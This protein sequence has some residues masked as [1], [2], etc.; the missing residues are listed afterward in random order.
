MT[1]GSDAT[2]STQDTPVVFVGEG[3]ARTPCSPAATCPSAGSWRRHTSKASAVPRTGCRG[4]TVRPR[5]GAHLLRRAA[6]QGGRRHLSRLPA[7]H[8]EAG[9]PDLRRLRRPPRRDH[10]RGLRPAPARPGH[11]Q[12]ARRRAWSTS[13]RPGPARSTGSGRAACCASCATASA[14]P[15]RAAAPP[16]QRRYAGRSSWCARSSPTTSAWWRAP[17]PTSG[18]STC[19]SSPRATAGPTRRR[20]SPPPAPTSSSTAPRPSPPSRRRFAGLNWVCATTARQRDLAKPVLTP[21]QAVAE[22][23]RRLARGPAL[24]HRVRAR[25]QRPGDGGGGQRRRRGHGAGQPSFASLNLAQAVLLVEL[26]VDEAVGRRN[27]RAGDHLR[28]AA[29]SPVCRPA[30]RRRRAGTSSSAF[31]EHIERELDA[32]GFFTAP[33]KRPSVVQNLRSMFVRMGATEQ[34]IRTL[35]GIVKALVHPKRGRRAARLSY[36]AFSPSDAALEERQ[37][38]P[39]RTRSGTT[40]REGWMR[41]GA[42]RCS[43]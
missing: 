27:A 5:A 39:T 41:Q 23:R 30:A 32:S 40:A 36:A 20:A 11:R 13:P 35:R 4:S 28:G 7:A 2:L 17:W 19:A 24:R 10:L 22:M 14:A 43:T 15:R 42:R 9:A 25:A 29:S 26:R 31:F 16:A 3:D 12:A 8:P 21:E 6:L 18:W 33:E 34:E 37:A 1:A 38:W